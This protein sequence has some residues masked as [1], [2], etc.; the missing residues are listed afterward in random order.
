[1]NEDLKK[2][3]GKNPADFEPAAC[4][5]VNNSDTKLFSE[6]VAQEDFLFDF[7]KQNVAQRLE[8]ACNESNYLNLLNFLKYYSPSYEN[9]IV[10][11][12][13]KYSNDD[14]NKR[15]L[16]I[17]E[18][19]SLEEKT[20]CAKYFS[21]TK[22][23]EAAEL[24][25]KFA[26]SEHSYLSA[27]CAAAL[28]AFGD[29]TLYDNSIEMLNSEDS[30]TQL[31]AVRFLVSY[32]DSSASD[33][34]I[35]TMMHSSMADNIAGELLYL[36]DLFSIY[37]K[38]A[39]QGL[40]VLNAVIEG[41]GEILNISQV[42]DF[43]LYEFLEMIIKEPVNPQTAVILLAAQDKFETLT[44][45]DEYLFDET[46]DTKQEILDIKNLLNT[47][48]T[49]VLYSLA[50]EELKHNSPFVFTA[51]EYTENEPLVRN[52]LNSSNPALV[53]KSLEVLKMLDTLT[54]QDK[55]TALSGISDE[56]LRAVINAI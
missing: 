53:L 50:D 14:L 32:G 38:N 52:L 54:A 29:R 6:L 1:M 41:L 11:T 33:A 19:G 23:P 4:S 46:K 8:K 16:D 34:I 15:L 5:V 35:K 3:T 37:K 21:V 42:F 43:Q 18:N 12:L 49:A 44:E 39:T 40:Y 27:N 20:Y 13:A 26:F 51:L 22:M 45:N 30:F 7:V 31:D 17:F 48:D 55:E 56:N 10:S 36:T 24:L 25:K 28:A 47:A 2:L 9:F